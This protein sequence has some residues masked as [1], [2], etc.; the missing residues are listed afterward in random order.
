M[1]A[2]RPAGKIGGDPGGEHLERRRLSREEIQVIK[3]LRTR[4]ACQ[5]FERS[6][7]VAKL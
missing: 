1:R 6:E 5:E 4:T 2:G 3:K 7:S